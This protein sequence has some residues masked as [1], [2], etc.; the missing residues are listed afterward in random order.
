MVAYAASLAVLFQNK[1]FSR[2]DAIS[3]L[4]I[5]GIAFPIIAWAA[6][7]RGRPLTIEARRSGAEMAVL[8]LCLVLVALYLIWGTA[9]SNA[10]LPASWVASPRTKFFVVMI[11]KL[12]V[13]VIVP[14]A[15]YRITFG[16]RW[17]DFGV[18]WQGL[19][20]SAG[21]HLPVVLVLSAAI[22]VFQYFMGGGAAP[23]RKGEFTADQLAIGL[24]L[25]FAWLFIEAGLVEEFFFRAV[26]Q[27]RCAA[28]FKSEVSGVALMA[29]CFGL[30]HA[31][32][33]ILRHAGLEEAIGANPSAADSIAYSIVV[34][35][36]GGIFF[37]VVWSRTKNLF[38]V[39]FIH[40]ATDLF[41]NLKQFVETWL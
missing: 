1:A 18:Q 3:E 24:P 6:T 8:G 27:T 36:V 10:L 5:F 14:F 11:R 33:F 40:A 34:L 19:R 23:L 9:W 31:P 28:W 22:L 4:I 21:N 38:A 16:Y 26:V 17:R 30:A 25:C 2:E 39:M 20:A 35:S 41:P 29:L 15:L 37:G 7:L 12:L 32:G 13:F